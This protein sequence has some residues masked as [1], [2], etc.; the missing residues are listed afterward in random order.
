MK[1]TLFI[2]ISCLFVVSCGKKVTCEQFPQNFIE[3][4]IPYETGQ[5]V[6]FVSD[7][8]DTMNFVVTEAYFWES[9]DYKNPSDVDCDRYCEPIYVK[10]TDTIKNIVLR[11]QIGVVKDYINFEIT[12]GDAYFDSQFVGDPQ[13]FKWY[14]KAIVFARETNIGFYVCDIYDYQGIGYFE[15]KTANSNYVGWYLISDHKPQIRYIS[16]NKKGCL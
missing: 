6:V 5:K 10:M 2:L 7:N 11:Y 16:A 3:K 9:Y 13:Y 14:A 1:K 4:Y 12:I 8:L 15:E